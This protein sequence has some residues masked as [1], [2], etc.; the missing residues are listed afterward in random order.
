MTWWQR[1]SWWRR[2]R[3][4]RLSALGGSP[5][6][7]PAVVPVAERFVPTPIDETA[8]R[9]EIESLV[10]G[11]APGGVDEA[12][13]APLDNLINALADQWLADVRA[14]HA[15]YVAR[16][17]PLLE[18][19]EASVGQT[20]VLAMHDHSV[21]AHKVLALETALLRMVGHDRSAHREDGDNDESG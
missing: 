20:D 19:V 2:R 16:A 9:R 8:A 3:G 5:P 13:G 18:R 14:Q 6:A 12:T 4:R 10:A 15:R 17:T 21:L 1:M 11:L 7:D